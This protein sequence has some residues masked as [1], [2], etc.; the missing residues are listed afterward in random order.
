MSSQEYDIALK[1]L[2]SQGGADVLDFLV[3][4]GR[5]AGWLNVELPS[6]RN[7]RVDLL[8]RMESGRLMQIEL[9]SGNDMTPERMLEYLSGI[10]SKLGTVPRQIV[11][12]VG[13]K[14]LRIR[15]GHEEEGL[16]FRY[17]VVDIRELDGEAMLQSD[18]IVVNVLS[19]LA[20]L[21]EPEKAVGRIMMK[22]AGLEEP[23][24]R[25]DALRKLLIVA[26]LRD[27]EEYV[28]EKG[29]DMPITM[30]IMDHKVFGPLIRKGQMEGREAG[31]LEGREEGREKVFWRGKSRSC[32]SC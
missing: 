15:R 8:A 24:R 5:V 28:E 13:N 30:D 10:W 7:P 16:T 18:S 11:M 12:Y 26:G 22:I 27:L 2:I 29:K 9:D 23:E 1:S 17:E 20:S 6:V 32:G 19:I 21:E 31:R 3:G 25:A 4:G 14:P